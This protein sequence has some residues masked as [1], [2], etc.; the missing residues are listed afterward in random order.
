MTG[1]S[2]ECRVLTEYWWYFVQ[3]ATL[4][5]HT[6]GVMQSGHAEWEWDNK[7]C[8]DENV[9]SVHRMYHG[10]CPGLWASVGD[11]EDTVWS[12]VTTFPDTRGVKLWVSAPLGDYDTGHQGPGVLG[13]LSPRSDRHR[14]H[15][16][17]NARDTIWSASQESLFAVKTRENLT[18]ILF[19]TDQVVPNGQKWPGT[20]AQDSRS[21]AASLRLHYCG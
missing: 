10:Q 20:E 4:P 8:R 3:L 18:N 5:V 14:L 11:A 16:C 13:S 2:T 15:I 21:S 19:R 17:N 7:K 6:D 12:V 1:T 9:W